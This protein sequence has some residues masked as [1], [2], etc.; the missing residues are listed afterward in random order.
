MDDKQALRAL[1]VPKAVLQPR[2]PAALRAIPDG[3]LVGGLVGIRDF[4]F[5]IGRESRGTMVDG[6]FHRVE[7]P[8]PA[9]W[10]PN[11]DLYLLDGGELLHVS[12][13]HCQIER[14]ADGFLL[15]DRGSACGICVGPVHAGGGHSAAH[16]SLQLRDGDTIGIGTTATPYLYTFITIAD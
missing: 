14:T 15:V 9:T 2:T 16:P 4:P 1:L 8:R 5:R 12:R 10:K 7:R 11:N 6:E 13:E 3:V